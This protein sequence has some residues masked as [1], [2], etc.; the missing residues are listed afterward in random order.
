[1]VCKVWMVAL[2]SAGMA[3]GQAT[4]APT[5]ATAPAREAADIR[6]GFDSTEYL[7]RC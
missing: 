5:P 6:C 1:M 3:M 2:L 7:W 4:S